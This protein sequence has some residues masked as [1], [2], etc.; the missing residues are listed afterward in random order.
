MR[1]TAWFNAS[2]TKSEPFGPKARAT[3]PSN[4]AWAAL[5]SVAPHSSVAPAKVVTAP[6]APTRRMAWFAESATK[7]APSLAMA[8]PSGELKRAAR[9]TALVAPGSPADPAQVDTEPSRPIRR[10]VWLPVSL[11]KTV[12][13]LA[14]ARADGVSKRAVAAGPSALPASPGRPAIVV[15]IP[16][17]VS[18]RRQWLAESA[19]KT[20]PWASMARPA[21]SEKRASAPTPSTWPGTWAAPASVRTAS[22]ADPVTIPRQSAAATANAFFIG[23]SSSGV[24]RPSPGRARLR[25]R[26]GTAASARARCRTWSWRPGLCA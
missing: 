10:S 17:G 22:D 16:A 20:L 13:S 8:M 3:G 25:A 6:S 9:P 12:P 21:G 23:P 5:P 14:T 26:P 4:R 1:R 15:T 11:T 19:I 18:L 7:R 24:R 2:L